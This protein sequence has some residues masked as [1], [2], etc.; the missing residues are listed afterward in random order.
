[1]ILNSFVLSFSS[2]IESVAA[3]ILHT[4]SIRNISDFVQITSLP[5]YFLVSFTQYFFV[6]EKI[7]RKL[8]TKIRYAM[9][10][11]EE[12]NMTMKFIR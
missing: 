2:E 7:C 1:M 12:N 9:Q 11:L 5:Q 10:K 4:L 6:F 3:I 8:E